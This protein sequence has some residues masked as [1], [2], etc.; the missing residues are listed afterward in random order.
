MPPD[1]HIKVGDASLEITDRMMESKLNL[2][3][4]LIGDEWMES[5]E[6]KRVLEQRIAEIRRQK[7]ELLPSLQVNFKNYFCGLTTFKL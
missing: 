3:M 4:R 1:L 7:G 6:R 5:R 2:N